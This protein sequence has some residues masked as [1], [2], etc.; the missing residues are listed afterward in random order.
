VRAFL[1]NSKLRNENQPIHK[2]LTCEIKSQNVTH[3][4]GEEMTAKGRWRHIQLKKR[5]QNY[6]KK[7]LLHI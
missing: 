7:K 6:K 3:E 5:S 4:C 2:Y 1:N